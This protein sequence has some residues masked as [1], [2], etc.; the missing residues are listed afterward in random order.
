MPRS[1]PL[2]IFAALYFV[3]SLAHFAH[4][5]EYIAYYPNMPR[6]V[7]RETV[8]LVWLA[9]TAVGA[10]GLAFWRLGLKTMGVLVL[11]VYGAL[12]PDG[13]A[14]YSLALCSEHTLAMNATI[15]FEAVS[16]VALAACCLAIAFKRQ[17]QENL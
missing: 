7:T 6:S 1:R 17:P 3:A 12:G 2:A 11:A 13:L 15:W 9:I 16:G 14:H 4:N 10:T 5:A 8:Y